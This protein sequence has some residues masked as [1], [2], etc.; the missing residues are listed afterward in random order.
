MLHCTIVHQSDPE[1]A[2]KAEQCTS[3]R[4]IPNITIDT[5]IQ[6]KIVHIHIH[7]MNTRNISFYLDIKLQ[8]HPGSIIYTK[9]TLSRT[10][11]KTLHHED[12]KPMHAGK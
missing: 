7:T 9:E 1:K 6:I 4:A 5:F 8:S 2:V 12:N 11:Y 3:T 10:K